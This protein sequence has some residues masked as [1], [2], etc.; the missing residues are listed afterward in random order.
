MAGAWTP[1]APSTAPNHPNQGDPFTPR[2]IYGD[3]SSLLL[4]EFMD[5]STSG[6]TAPYS[7]AMPSRRAPA[8]V[9]HD[10][11]LETDLVQWFQVLMSSTPDGNPPTPMNPII[12]HRQTPAACLHRW[13]AI[14]THAMT[15]CRNEGW[16][17]AYATNIM[18]LISCLI[19][20]IWPTTRVAEWPVTSEYS[21]QGDRHIVTALVH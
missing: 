19:Q 20:G 2:Y 14:L 4:L 1:P 8:F 10:P 3:I 12:R 11:D 7:N 5:S 16:V 17:E 6:A 13:D 15:P 21:Q 18:S 9:L